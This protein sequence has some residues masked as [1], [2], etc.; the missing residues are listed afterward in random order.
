M[1]IKGRKLCLV[2]VWIAVNLFFPPFVF[3]YVQNF[4]SSDFHL[5]LQESQKAKD[6]LKS[7]KHTF[8]RRIGGSLV[9][10]I[11]D[12]CIFLFSD[13]LGSIRVEIF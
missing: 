8:Q 12:V 4:D 5:L 3:F 6:L 11:A 2:G 10:R 1:H 13:V 7:I 9:S